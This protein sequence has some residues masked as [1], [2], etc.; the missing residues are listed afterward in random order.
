MNALLL[1]DPSPSLRWRAAVE[2]DGASEN[3]AEV[4]AWRAEIDGGEE[5]RA[6][7][8]QLGAARDNPQ[9]AGYLLCRLTYLG[10]RGP[11]LAAAVDGIFAHQQLDGRHTASSLAC[12]I[13]PHVRCAGGADGRTRAGRSVRCG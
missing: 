2:L 12:P 9:T 8:A 4:A 7:V 11:E 13:Q 5:I 3:D 1:G 6:L 10:Y